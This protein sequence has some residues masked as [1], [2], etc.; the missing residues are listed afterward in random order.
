MTKLPE[1]AAASQGL[2]LVKS[3][4]FC[5]LDTGNVGLYHQGIVGII[6]HESGF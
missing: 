4:V 2:Y 6:H 3:V 5:Q 1:K